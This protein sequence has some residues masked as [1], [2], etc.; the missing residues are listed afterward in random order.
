MKISVVV[1]A[2]NEEKLLPRMLESLRDAVGAFAER[3]WES[4][5]IVCDNNSTDRT[6]AIAREHGARVVSEPINQ[7]GRARN[8]GAAAAT[9]DWLLFLDA[10]SLPTRELLAEAADRV[11]AGDVI[12]VGACVAL[13]GEVRPIARMFLNGWNTLS[14]TLRWMAGSFVLVE[15]SAFREIGGFS[16]QL[17]AGEEL[18]LSR[19]LKALAKR[20]GRKVAILRKHALKSSARRVTMYSQWE[21][22]RFFLRAVWRPRA[23]PTSREACG[24]WYDGRR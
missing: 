5:T 17:Y 8:S 2:F 11:A 4:E 1:P 16:L 6:A 23:T 14:R 12:F 22:L 3:G 7:I 9:G 21:I 18:D 24:M 10:D 19:R 13:D 15:T 20:R